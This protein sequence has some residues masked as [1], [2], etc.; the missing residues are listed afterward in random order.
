[1]NMVQKNNLNSV[2]TLEMHLLLLFKE[3]IQNSLTDYSN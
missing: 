1:M 2:I 3:T